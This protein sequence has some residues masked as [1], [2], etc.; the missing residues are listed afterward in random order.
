[1][2]T[3]TTR[4]GKGS[5][6]TNNE[7][8][9]NF[10]NLNADKVEI[11]GDLSG[12]PTAP[13]VTK[14]QGQSFSSD[15]PN[16]GEKLVWNGTAWEPA[17]DPSGEPIGHEDK[18]Q[19]SIS[20]NTGT[21]TFTIAPVSASFV[22]WCKGVKHTYTSAQTVV[23]PNTTGLHFIYFNASGVLSTQMT[24]FTWEEH[25]PT[26]Y[27]Y[28]N[29]TTQQ[30]VYF[31]DERH[32]ITLDWQTHEYL[33]RTR[34]AA[35]ASGFGA[36]GYTT[37]GTGATD[38]DAQ[39]DIG[40]GTFFDEDMQVDIVST[41]SP[42]ANT[43]QQDL[44][45]PAR[46]P[47]L[48]LS[49]NAWVIDAP[50]DFPFKVV[51]GIPQY[52][53]YSGGT[54]STASV[55][56]NGYFVSWILATNNLNYPVVSIIS[57]APTNQLSQAEA[58][59]FEGLSLS[60]FPSVEFRPLYKV[61]Y[62]HK[63][64][65]ANSVKA[66]TVAVYD[67]RALQSAGVAA[68]LVQDHGNLS[69]LGDDD[70][71]QYLH[72]SEVRSPSSAVKNSFLPS[73]TSNSGKY[74]ST[75]GTNPSWVAIP[76][77]S[78]DFTGDVTGTGTT[79]S[80]VALTLAN[81]GVTAGTYSK[82]TVDGKGR[83]TVGTN[84]ASG[85]VTT[86][87]GFTPE[88]AANKGV[89]NGYVGLDGSGKIASSHLPSYV[90]DV[91]EY[92]NL[93]AF[94]ATGDSGKIYIAIDS[95]KVYRWSGSA[96]VEISASPG[97]TD[98]VPEGSTNLY[99]TTS[100]VRTSISAS[101]S[102]SYNNTT[103]V[104][105][106]TTPSSDG[107]TE[108][109]TN[110]YFTNARARSAVSAAGSLS[111]NSSTGVFSY[112]QP[113][114]VSTFTNDS[115][116]L[117]GITG[118]QVTTAL[119]YTP[120]NSTNPSGY[121]SGITSGMVTTALGYTPYNSANPSGYITSSALSSYLPLSG[122]TLTGKLTVTA[123]A[124]LD[125]YRLTFDADGTDSWYRAGSGNRHRFTTTGGNDFIIANEP[126]IAFLGG[127]Q[128]VTAGNYTT[129][130]PTKTGGGASGTWNISV[131]GNAATVTNGLYSLVYSSSVPAAGWYRVAT[132][133]SDG[134]GTYDV[135]VFCTGGSNNPSLAKVLAQGDWG[136]DK[137]L[138]AQWDTSFPANQVRITRS[139]SNTFLE[140]YFTGAVPSFGIR[141]NRT[142]FD[143]GVYGY[144]G[145]LPAGGDTVND[146]LYLWNKTNL[147]TL[148]VKGTAYFAGGVS[149]AGATP[150]TTAS[151][152]NF[153]LTPSNYGS[154]YFKT[155]NGNSLIGPGD[156]S[157]STSDSTKLPLAGGT[158][159][160][161][162]ISSVAPAAI[163]TTT[164]GTTNYGF[165]FNGA[166]SPDNAQAITWTWAS[167]GGAQ[168][169]IYVQSSGSYGTRMYLATTDSFATGAKTAISID[170]SGNTN[171]V[172]GALRQGGNQVLHAGNYNDYAPTK[173]GG[174]ASGTWAIN[175]SGNAATATT[176]SNSTNLGGNAASYYDHRAYNVANNY[177][178]AYYVGDGGEKPN[179][180]I[181]GA[182]KL[183]I[184]MLS[185]GNLGFGGPWNDVI[186]LSTYS[187]GDVKGSYAIACDKYSDEI[188]FSR[189]NYDSATWG[190]GRR[191]L[192]SGNYTSFA[193]TKSG[194]TS[195]FASLT[196]STQGT[197][198]IR[199]NQED[200]SSGYY[201]LQGTL[202]GTEQIRIER[203]GSIVMGSYLRIASNNVDWATGNYFRGTN[204]H[205]VLGVQNGGTLY[206]N[207]GNS[208][209]TT[210]IDGSTWSPIF[211][212]MDNS[213]YYLNPAG[214]SNLSGTVTVNGGKLL[215]LSDSG[216][217][218]QVQINS[219]STNVEATLLFGAGGSGQNSGGYTYA[220]VIG[221]GAYGLSKSNLY[222]G[223]SYGGPAF[224]I[225]W[226]GDYAQAQGSFRAPIFYD[227]N[228]TGYYL[229]PASS[230]RL[231]TIYCGDVYNDL[232]G[233]FRNYGATG[234]YNQS[235]GNHFYSDS[236]N[237]WNVSHGG[238]SNGGIRFRD[239]HAGTIRGYVYADTSNN[240]G[241]LNSGGSWRARVVGDDYFLV[242]G[243]SAR[244]PLYYDSNNTSYYFRP[245]STDTGNLRG[246]LR[247]G[248]YGA[249]IC[250]TYSSYR[251]QLVFAMGDAYKASLDGTSV[252]G[253]YGLWYS[254]PNAGGV[255]SN[256]SSHGLMN[257]VNGSFHA[258]LDASMRAVSDMRSPIYYDIDNTGYYVNAAGTSQLSYVLANDWFRPQGSTGIY[259]NDYAYY[260]YKN[261]DTYGNF[262][263]GV[264]PQNSY[265]GIQYSYSSSRAT[266]MFDSAGNGGL[267]NYSYWIYYWLVGNACLGVRTSTTSSSYAMYVD[268]GIYSTGN[269]VAYS[270]VRKK[271][272]I[273]TVNNALDTVLKLRGVYYNRIETNDEKV[274][275]NKRQIGVIA[276]EVNEV[277]PEVVTYAKDVDEYGVQYGNM[278]GL[279]IEAIK[280][281]KAEIEDL[282]RRLN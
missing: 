99:H 55:N 185:S 172:R 70:H 194:T 231:S 178:G 199:L 201:L 239:N 97:S 150:V 238:A 223:C 26:A 266:T 36:S 72:V 248:D 279:F 91:L 164:P 69:G 92:A 19:S 219:S 11:G 191:L 95:A 196:A 142:G 263:C 79:G 154:G 60:G 225:P 171:I 251:Y 213:A 177:L 146:S 86:A 183:K 207:Y 153:A 63:T 14:V 255:A 226:T 67:L 233:W 264:N 281:L 211:Y 47:V 107:I 53:L 64:G 76:S 23:I 167:G 73:Q 221:L 136:N 270:D 34:G 40:G 43:W 214:S 197:P 152:G 149:F 62:T 151:I 127:H 121:I 18:S 58:M 259:W 230:S 277:L 282:K 141:V 209:G 32:G 135:E 247:F 24:Y 37:T 68:A 276:Q 161:T 224:F 133:G 170:E 245:A 27:I 115:G 159:T 175:I 130:A 21:R 193:V 236:Q 50:T 143:Q 176:A 111:Y 81:S 137:I 208:S 33:H 254:H 186:W 101:G 162:L 249:G 129:Y 126:N 25:A 106:Y 228:N 15:V 57:Q 216:G 1:M 184:A 206:L 38:A 278:A 41:N 243:S 16:I 51:G 222:F 147:D 280:E 258:S 132:T 85:D 189:Q 119:G 274:D 20:F 220:G 3:I 35:I 98:A 156:I 182:G 49:G 261:P 272:N 30:A 29:A 273:V 173:T 117:T 52:N 80:P 22:V 163:N 75:D 116:Y 134:R 256:L 128:L 237:Y 187:G 265:V 6:L 4:A 257:I 5:P 179:N 260:F 39:I 96:Y 78:L 123:L 168:A 252:S 56:N 114:N 242:E 9:A 271:T 108:G 269:V 218:G 42:V 48:Y 246:V 268:G 188:Y 71:A 100:R 59:T 174:N 131:S 253:G 90:D 12:T 66:S 180:A 113:T 122:G 28:W 109:S 94:P 46:I 8:D 82:V 13:I 110:L 103:G 203:D 7:L 112:T 125:L 181:F 267:Y 229:D 61:I 155:V 45:S 17:T 275:P 232:G 157:I 227:S 241:F 212:D 240:I 169:G 65:F 190:T 217:Y 192:H 148:Y 74:L 250:G 31:G 124:G 120:Y 235:Y 105:S 244:A 198:I 93:A 145:S 210:R 139:A 204:N 44:S 205:F 138:S 234:I 102:L 87:L 165:V 89:A 144:S 54:W 140:F 166:S 84:I 83:V 118:A 262:R 104:F 158:L 215:V 195:G 202:G 88:D 10:T 77:G 200:T 2:S 160:G